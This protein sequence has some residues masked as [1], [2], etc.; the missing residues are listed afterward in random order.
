[1][2]SLRGKGQRERDKEERD[3]ERETRRQSSLRGKRQ[4]ERDKEERDRE[5]ETRRQTEGGTA[6]LLHYYCRNNAFSLPTLSLRGGLFCPLRSS[7]RFCGGTHH[8][9]LI[10]KHVRAFVASVT[11]SGQSKP[12]PHSEEG[13]KPCKD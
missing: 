12:N 8:A 9:E 5:R 6:M 10:K 7:V 1:M 3:R 2:S 13:V 11:R 4:R